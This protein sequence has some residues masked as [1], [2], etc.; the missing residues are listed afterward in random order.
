M[1][2]K[3]IIRVKQWCDTSPD[4]GRG[5]TPQTRADPNKGSELSS[6]SGALGPAGPRAL[7]GRWLG[8]AARAARPAFVRVRWPA[9]VDTMC[10]S[11][12]ARDSVP[13]LQ[14]LCRRRYHHDEGPRGPVAPSCRSPA[15]F[16][17]P[18]RVHYFA[19]FPRSPNSKPAAARP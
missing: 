17:R 10:R 2:P 6:L 11:R 19:S 4:C 7:L 1:D 13:R 12:A 16:P 18:V 8:T 5:R 3:L 9:A 15:Q 14:R